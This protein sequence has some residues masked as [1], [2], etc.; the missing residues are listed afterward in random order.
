MGMLYAHA[1]TEESVQGQIGL[2]DKIICGDAS[3]EDPAGCKLGFETWWPQINSLIF[4]D[5]A[6]AFV[7]HGLNGECQL[8]NFRAW[9][10]QTCKTDVKAVA[11]LYMEQRT[12]HMIVE[13]LS[14]EMFCGAQG[15]DEAGVHVCQDVVRK[16]IPHA[17]DVIFKHL[18]GNLG[19][20]CHQIYDGVCE[21]NPNFW[22]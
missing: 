3:V 6:G 21:H 20:A 9:N 18:E 16:V 15:L 1:T 5:R 11:E 12:H 13:F 4:N 22:L 10:C 14:G 2:L 19:H 17:I 8:P 7:C